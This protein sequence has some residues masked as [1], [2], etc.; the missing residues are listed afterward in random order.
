MC[1]ICAC[2]QV[3]GS[4]WGVV[5]GWGGPDTLLPVLYGVIREGQG[6]GRGEDH[7]CA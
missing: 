4:A 2:L 3:Y 7:G 1:M 6:P 5:G